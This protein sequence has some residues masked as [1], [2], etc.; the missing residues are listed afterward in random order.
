MQLGLSVA[1]AV[2]ECAASWWGRCDLPPWPPRHKPK[3]VVNISEQRPVL[4]HLTCDREHV[5]FV[6]GSPGDAGKIEAGFNQ[7]N[8]WIG[9]HSEARWKPKSDVE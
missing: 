8:T 7:L 4:F 3:E 6:P 5:R 2:D 1:A 9:I